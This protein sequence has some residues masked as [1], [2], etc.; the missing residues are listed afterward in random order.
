M[1]AVNAVTNDDQ[2]TRLPGRLLG[3]YS[4]LPESSDYQKVPGKIGPRARVLSK[5]RPE[6]SKKASIGVLQVV[7]SAVSEYFKYSTFF[8]GL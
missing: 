1:K 4:R 3:S 6:R 8:L 5:S 7:W 2:T